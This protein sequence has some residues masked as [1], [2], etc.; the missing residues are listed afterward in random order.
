MIIDF[1]LEL[2]AG[3]CVHAYNFDVLGQMQ[4]AFSLVPE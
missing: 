1:E 4:A 3:Y 2:C